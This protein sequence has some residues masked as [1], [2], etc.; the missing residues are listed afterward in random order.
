MGA[1]KGLEDRGRGVKEVPSDGKMR[2]GGGK[3]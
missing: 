2:G 3:G 1:K